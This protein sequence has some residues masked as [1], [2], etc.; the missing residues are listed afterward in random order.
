MLQREMTRS[1]V[2]NTWLDNLKSK[3]RSFVVDYCRQITLLTS[4]AQKKCEAIFHRASKSRDCGDVALVR[5]VLVSL[6]M[7][8]E[9]TLVVRAR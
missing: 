3:I 7:E 6:R 5:A 1:V 2:G 9:Q 8:K 4:A